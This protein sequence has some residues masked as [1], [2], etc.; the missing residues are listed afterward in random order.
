M[1]TETQPTE[2]AQERRNRI[3]R[4]A[5]AAAKDAANGTETPTDGVENSDPPEP[6]DDFE[7]GPNRTPATPEDDPP[8][9]PVGGGRTSAG[10]SPQLQM[11]ETVLDVA[12][13]RELLID[14]GTLER[15]HDFKLEYERA[16]RKAWDKFKTLG[17]GDG[18]AHAYRLQEY[19][20]SWP[21]AL[22]DEKLITFTR[23]PTQ[24]VTVIHTP[25]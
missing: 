9:M 14:L 8:A 5:R 15:F 11:D 22:G 17:K 21:E 19:R 12:D 10:E 2:T 24:K 20:I 4:E 16:H 7:G 25:T 23:G 18:K 1:A 13:Y 6:S 3:K